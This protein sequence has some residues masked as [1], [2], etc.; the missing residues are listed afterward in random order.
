METEIWQEAQALVQVGAGGGL[1][2]QQS[3]EKWTGFPM[4]V[5]KTHNEL[6]KYFHL[7]SQ[8]VDFIQIN[9]K[10]TD[11]LKEKWTKNINMQFA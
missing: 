9:K 2:Q 3:G 11:S 1:D 8:R 7:V 6:E 10:S 5:P 4:G